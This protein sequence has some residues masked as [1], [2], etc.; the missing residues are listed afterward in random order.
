MAERIYH[1]QMNDPSNTDGKDVFRPQNENGTFM[2]KDEAIDKLHREALKD[3]GM[4]EAQIRGRERM[5]AFKEAAG[6]GMERCRNVYGGVK[7]KV[8]QAV[9]WLKKAGVSAAGVGEKVLGSEAYVQEAAGAVAERGREIRDD[10][11]ARAEAAK[12]KMVEA[13][14]RT[15]EK[16][17]SL[18]AS[19][20]ERARGV[21]ETGR[22]KV[23]AAQRN[24]K[25]KMNEM[26]A[27]DLLANAE[28]SDAIADN[29]EDKAAK[30]LA[31]AANRRESA[32]QARDKAAELA[33][34]LFEKQD[35]QA[36]TSPEAAQSAN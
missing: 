4:S 34:W 28:R 9:S 25:D 18:W 8:G 26:Y 27:G 1:D 11:K 17:K 2:K 32:Q 12:T 20:L 36:G 6:R 14:Q 10:L 31:S 35:E 21:Y 5:G 15:V 7:E 23:V 29:E 30:L 24:I 33:P 19:A 22:E 13:G 3:N 16:G